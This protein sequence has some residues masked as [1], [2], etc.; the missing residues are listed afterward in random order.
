MSPTCS[1]SFLAWSTR[2]PSGV[3]PKRFSAWRLRSW[4]W[5]LVR[6]TLYV[7]RLG[8]FRRAKHRLPLPLYD[9][10]FWRQSENEGARGRSSTSEIKCANRHGK[11]RLLPAMSAQQRAK[12]RFVPPLLSKATKPSRSPAV[13][14]ES[15]AKSCIHKT[16]WPRA[17][18]RNLTFFIY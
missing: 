4:S 16:P 1:R 5:R 3:S 8:T 18:N 7:L 12:L 14:L 11:R 2:L 17:L 9:V 13:C 10:I 6:R 15:V